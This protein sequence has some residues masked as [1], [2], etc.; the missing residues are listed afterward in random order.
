M[1][2]VVGGENHRTLH[3]RKD[4]GNLPWA[5]RKSIVV[6]LSWQQLH[7]EM[8]K[9]ARLTLASKGRSSDQSQTQVPNA[10]QS[11]SCSLLCKSQRQ[12]IAPIRNPDPQTTTQS[13]PP[14]HPP[15]WSARMLPDR[16]PPHPSP[17]GP[18]LHRMPPYGPRMVPVW[19]LYG[20]RMDHV[21]PP[22]APRLVRMKKMRA[23]Y[24]PR[25]G[26]VWAP[27]GPRM[28]PVWPPY[29]PPMVPVWSPYG[30]RIVPV[31][32]P[33]GPRMVPVWSPYGP[34]MVPVWPP[35]GPRMVPVWSPYGP[36]V[37]SPD[38]VCSATP[39]VRPRVLSPPPGPPKKKHPSVSVCFVFLS[40]VSVSP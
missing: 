33:Y 12:P 22:Y 18:E 25:M 14:G 29:G 7:G 3:F 38:P 5:V 16:P 2:Q 13:S 21:L 31:W 28:G 15:P 36:R 40:S 26:P 27:Y 23:P 8:N 20:P 11:C 19:S 6:D 39:A 9:F 32:A 1:H 37:I 10:C 24:G 4:T 34:R 17:K 30:P 35:Y